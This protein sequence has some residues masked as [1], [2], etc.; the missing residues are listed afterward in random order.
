[1]KV[2]NF[3]ISK[4]LAEI[5]FEAEANFVYRKADR[6]LL[7]YPYG[8][9]KES[10]VK[11]RFCLAYDLETILEAL[12]MVIE[13]DGKI[14]ELTINQRVRFDYLDE[15]GNELVAYDGKVIFSVNNRIIKYESLADT[16]AKLLILLYAKGLSQRVIDTKTEKEKQN[17]LEVIKSGSVVAWQHVN[18]QG[19]YDFS[20]EILKNSIKF[21]L[22][23]LLELQI[24]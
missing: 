22:P 23:E 15:D 5:G 18:L 19:E 9:M 13:Q 20:D 21:Q 6:E 24:T 3:E 2:T 12:P 10:S 11:E 1:M 7:V 14:Y 16:A 17:L 4:K 8:L